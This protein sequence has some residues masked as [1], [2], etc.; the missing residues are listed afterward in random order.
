MKNSIDVP[1]S[2]SLYP[3][4]ESNFPVKNYNNTFFMCYFA[5]FLFELYPCVSVC[6]IAPK[7]ATITHISN[8]WIVNISFTVL[9]RLKHSSKI[10]HKKMSV[11]ETERLIIFILMR[12]FLSPIFTVVEHISNSRPY[13]ISQPSFSTRLCAHHICC[14]FF[15]FVI[16]SVSILY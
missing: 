15:L 1:T 11:T 10:A 14:C 6:P 8:V 16:A 7:T 12:V 9:V 5:F 13:S 2:Q 4:C 3:G